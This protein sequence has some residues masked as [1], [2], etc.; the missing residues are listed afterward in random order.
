MSEPAGAQGTDDRATDDR[1]AAWVEAV[2]SAAATAVVCPGVS[3]RVVVEITGG[4]LLRRTHWIID[5]G[6]LRSAGIGRIPG[7][8]VTVS[9]S[10]DDAAAVRNG[11][12]DPSVAWMQGRANVTGSPAAWL[13][14]L[15]STA[16]PAFR[17]LRRDAAELQDAAG[18]TR[19]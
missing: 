16:T 4:D 15:A 12:L 19:D 17:R 11:V 7:P 8:D 3:A 13:A 14:L 9:V 5:Q 18:V 2:T 10:G 6:V 1:D